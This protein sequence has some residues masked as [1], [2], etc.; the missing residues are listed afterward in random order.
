V[1]Q[2]RVVVPLRMILVLA[3]L[4]TVT[5]IATA[6]PAPEPD[7][8]PRLIVVIAVDGL[9]PE[10]F[11]KLEPLYVGG[12][13]RLLAEGASFSD[14]HQDHAFTYTGPGH[15]SLL[16]GRFPGSAGVISNS[17]YDRAKG[18]WVYCVEDPAASLVGGDE[19]GAPGSAGSY[20]PVAATALGDWMVAADPASRVVSIAG[21]DRAAIL[22]GGR[23]AHA[24]YWFDRSLGRWV[25][26]DAVSD[27]VHPWVSSMEDPVERYGGAR[28]ERIVADTA[29]YETTFRPDVFP[30][31]RD[32][33]CYGAPDCLD[34]APVFD[35]RPVEGRD[36]D[37]ERVARGISYFPFLDEMV[38][39][40]G[41]RALEAEGLGR[42]DV[43]DLLCLGFSALDRVSHRA[44][45]WS[46]EAMDVLLRLDR[47]LDELIRRLD[48]EVGEGRYVLALSS[49]HGFRPLVAESRARG[50][51][52]EA[53]GDRGKIFRDR[54]KAA[55]A[56]E[57]GLD[58][59]FV[60]TTRTWYYLDHTALRVAGVSADRVIEV[61]RREA[62][63][64]DW[65]DRVL[66]RQELLGEAPPGD[67]LLRRYRHSLHPSRMPE[68]MLVPAPWI[69]MHRNEMGSTHGSPHPVDAHV[70][71]LVMGPGTMPGTH[72]DFVRTVDLAPTLAHLIAVP[73]PDEVDGRSLRRLLAR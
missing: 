13:R 40:L 50:E 59:P 16:S 38:L 54:V 42:D 18:D 14:C 26:S 66:A 3:V 12:F 35:H 19:P 6:G 31:E 56:R 39:E 27:S 5:S 32:L 8:P 49:D 62:R 28:W 15:F 22:M 37:R 67:D 72:P 44:G 20:R 9:A 29:V 47:S 7:V 65:I 10:P 64:V 24:V 21:K 4:A 71:L 55:L 30:G 69:L 45:P 63:G 51:R 73:V 48:E 33:S 61:V 11:E 17:W 46:Q 68:I 41:L 70:P 58:G 36:L 34:P 2:P 1:R 53:I 60:E 25:T 23:S 57:L 43:P 52:A